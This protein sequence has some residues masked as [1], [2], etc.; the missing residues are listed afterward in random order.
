MW[1]FLW[2][3]SMIDDG[4]MSIS[5]HAPWSGRTGLLNMLL[6]LLRQQKPNWLELPEKLS[7]SALLQRMLKIPQHI[8]T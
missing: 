4:C 3:A 2:F 8:T 1:P 6:Q 5:A 7:D